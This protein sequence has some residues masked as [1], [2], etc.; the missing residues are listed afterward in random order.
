MSEEGDFRDVLRRAAEGG[1]FDDCWGGDQA[2]TD[3]DNW[4]GRCVA[5][6][7]AM[8]GNLEGW[9]IVGVEATILPGGRLR[10]RFVLAPKKKPGH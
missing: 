1:A 9:E 5:R 4:R 8:A 6:A 7:R 10:P 2:E 3:E